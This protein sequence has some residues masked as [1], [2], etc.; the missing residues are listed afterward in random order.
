MIPMSAWMN[1]LK[2]NWQNK[3]NLWHGLAAV[4][5]MGVEIQNPQGCADAD[6]YNIN[7][8]LC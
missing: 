7:I 5:T 3:V 8:V 6:L 4:K 2:G 1:Y